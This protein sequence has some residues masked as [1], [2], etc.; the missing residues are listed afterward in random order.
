MNLV[1]LV[2]TTLSPLQLL[3]CCQWIEQEL[4]RVRLIKWGPRVID[5]DILLFA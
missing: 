1:V 4:G 3:D 2:E 5:V